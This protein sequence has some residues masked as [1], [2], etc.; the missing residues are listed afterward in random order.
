MRHHFFNM[1][2]ARVRFCCHDDPDLPHFVVSDRRCPQLR[3]TQRTGACPLKARFDPT[4][5]LL[6]IPE[7]QLFLCRASFSRR[8]VWTGH[9]RCMYKVCYLHVHTSGGGCTRLRQ[10]C[11]FLF[12]L[13]LAGIVHRDLK[14]ENILLTD[15][16]Q[17]C[18]DIKIVDFGLSRFCSMADGVGLTT[19]CGSPAYV[20][21]EILSFSHSKKVI[22][23][24]FRCLVHQG[25]ICFDG[26]M[27]RSLKD[28]KALHRSKMPRDAVEGDN[29]CF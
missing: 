2:A 7:P 20:A 5:Y 14:L 6:M 8:G 4:V 10:Y 27:F 25:A 23:L 29:P 18:V 26:R 22:T 1:R 28:L 12:V 21:P 3:I 13:R 17:G 24:N 9:M 11:A 15:P 16:D 19:M